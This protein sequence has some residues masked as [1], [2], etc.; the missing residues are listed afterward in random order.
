MQ[1]DPLNLRSL[2]NPA[3][4]EDLWPSIAA[5]LD[6]PPRSR[7]RRYLPVA[8]AAS[9]VLAVT[10]LQVIDMADDQPTH[11][12]TE[13]SELQLARATSARLE[14]LLRRQRDGVLDAT[15]VESLA[16]ME[17]ELG[18]LDVQLADN[19]SETRLWR[20]RAELLAE[21]ASQ[22]ERNNWQARIQLASY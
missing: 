21:M 19:P 22:Y 11:A 20:Q 13:Y 18:W 2:P 12:T 17:Q 14:Q 15:A 1:N 6:D 9:L 7:V 10:G 4:P 5:A 8:L 3:P 16:W